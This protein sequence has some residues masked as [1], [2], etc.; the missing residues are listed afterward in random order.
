MINK[1]CKLCQIEKP[2]EEFTTD[3]RSKNPVGPC[4]ECLKE[5]RNF[6]I[7]SE[8]SL[9]LRKPPFKRVAYS[10]EIEFCKLYDQNMNCA[11]ISK[12]TGFSDDTVAKY[13]RLH[14]RDIK[15]DWNVKD[16]NRDI[17]YFDI[18]NTEEKAYFLGLLFADGC[19]SVTNT[20]HRINI[21]LQ[22][23]DKEILELM[24]EK[25]LGNKDSLFFKPPKLYGKIKFN[26]AYEFR[27]NSRYLSELLSSYGMSPRKSMTLTLP[28]NVNFT[29]ELWQAFFRGYF[30]GD[31]WISVPKQKG[32]YKVGFI[33]SIE[34]IEH[35]IEL[36][37][38]LS[39]LRLNF[40][41][42]DNNKKM[43]IAKVGGIFKSK[44]FLDWLYKDSTIHLGRKY[45]RYLNLCEL[46]KLRKIS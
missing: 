13:L 26:G 30:D 28:K 20:C 36:I 15:R 10:N 23:K 11:E 6:K 45:Q 16:K 35:S 32:N 9:G 40:Y 43:A 14:G 12:A 24:A 27:I 33:S 46:C 19:N 38:K 22:I 42:S 17:H 2:K 4:K 37:E 25:I 44:A 39:G 8:I 29:P 34:F 3:Y 21:S 7:Q 1:L 31:G 18:I 41:F 5:K